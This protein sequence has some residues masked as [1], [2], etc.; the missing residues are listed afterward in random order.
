MPADVCSISTPDGD[1]SAELLRPE[2]ATAL[3]VLAHGAGAGF[4]HASL[5]AVA[6][7]LAARQVANLRF[8]FPFMEAGRRRVDAR[9]VAVAA[10]AEAVRAAAEHSPDLPLFLGG[11]SFGGRMA[12][13]AVAEG[14]VSVRALVCLSFPLHPA[15]RPGVERGAHLAGI[16][17][18]M[19]FL[20]GTR[21]A[22]AEPALLTRV[23]AGLGP[24]AR[25]HWLDDADHGYR[26]RKR[27]RTDSRSVFDEIA[28]EAAAF[29]AAVSP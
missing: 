7:A 5:T 8:N 29:L 6:E 19:L 11:H 27:M 20:S 21:D 15:N 12:S 28:E 26:V 24:R 17:I 1:L 9:P 25:L 22:L 13:H 2:R 10:L 3:L 23:V 16:P 4:R 14:R 18:P